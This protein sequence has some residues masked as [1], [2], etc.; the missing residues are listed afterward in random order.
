MNKLKKIISDQLN[1]DE[2]LIVPEAKFTE[3]LLA[4]SLDVVELVMAI[5]E[6]YSLQIPDEDTDD[7]KTVGIR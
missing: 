1:L 5:E 6:A 4:D 7:I 3:D 2:N